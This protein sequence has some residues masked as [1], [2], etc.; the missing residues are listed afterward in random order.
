MHVR[1]DTTEFGLLSCDNL[2]TL[3]WGQLTSNSYIILSL[4]NANISFKEGMEQHPD[5]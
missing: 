2:S 3:F 4:S 1:V 5:E